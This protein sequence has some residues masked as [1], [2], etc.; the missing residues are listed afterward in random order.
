M[1][2]TLP[3][4]NHHKLYEYDKVSSLAYPYTPQADNLHYVSTKTIIFVS[5]FYLY[6]I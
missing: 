1:A 5:L 4:G 6:K 3:I 2:E